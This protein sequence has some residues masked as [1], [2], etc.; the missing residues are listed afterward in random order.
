VRQGRR[1]FVLGGA[2]ICAAPRLAAGQSA[3]R[4]LRLAI[5]SEATEAARAPNWKRF[6]GRLAELGYVEGRNLVVEARHAE[7]VPARLP[8]LAAELVAW[9]PDVVVAV[10][11][12]SA[13]AAKN[14][15]ATIPVVFVGPADPVGSGL[16]TNLGRPGGNVTGFSPMQAEIGGK[17]IELLRELVPGLKRAAYLT[18]TG[19][20]GEMLVFE[21]IRIRASSL[22]ADVHAYDGV[23]NGALDRSFAAIGGGRVD[24]L[25]VALTQALLPHRE[26]IIAFASQKRIPAIYAR[27]E[28]PDAGGLLSYGADTAPLFARAAEYVQRIAQGAKPAE[29]PVERPTFVKMVVNQ[30]AA[31]AQGIRIPPSVLVGADEVIE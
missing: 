17:W 27:R 4:A 12:P 11:T 21:Q 25:M 23:A 29:L 5:L 20:G 19:N 6:F 9:R 15:T 18:D 26:R 16:V 7:G 24:G 31:R 10:A 14:A 8:A 30:R 22:G 1:R 28:Y 3:D 13:V 2:A